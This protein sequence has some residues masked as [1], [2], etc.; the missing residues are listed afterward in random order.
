MRT[1]PLD[2]SS[3]GSCRVQGPASSTT[4]GESWKGGG[5]VGGAWNEMKSP[6]RSSSLSLP[7]AP[8]GTECHCLS[9][10]IVIGTTSLARDQKSR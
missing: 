5:G 6:A 2:G 8:D 4:E 10:P 9:L 3:C 7:P 1:P